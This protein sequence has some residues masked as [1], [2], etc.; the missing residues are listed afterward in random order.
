VAILEIDWCS[1]SSPIVFMIVSTF[2]FG[3]GMFAILVDMFEG[4]VR[5]S[6]DLLIDELIVPDI[7]FSQGAF[8]LKHLN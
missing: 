5:V 2:D 3:K 4:T 1:G 6:Y 8:I 7:L